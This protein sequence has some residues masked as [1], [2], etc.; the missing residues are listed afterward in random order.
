MRTP[1]GDWRRRRSGLGKVGGSGLSAKVRG[2]GAYRDKRIGLGGSVCEMHDL[3][4]EFLSL[5]G[6]ERQSPGVLGLT[7][8]GVFGP[9]GKASASQVTSGA[10]GFRGHLFTEKGPEDQR[11]EVTRACLASNSPSLPLSALNCYHT[12]SGAGGRDRVPVGALLQE[13]GT[14]ALL[15]FRKSE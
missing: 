3:T 7:K 13:N 8:Q 11:D 5:V 6:G 4:F 1:V 10:R 2:G 15:A 12:C 14:T 9:P